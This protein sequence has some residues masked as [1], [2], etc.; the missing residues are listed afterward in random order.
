MSLVCDEKNV[1]VRR[2]LTNQGG[3]YDILKNGESADIYQTKDSILRNMN[4]PIYNDINDQ[5]KYGKFI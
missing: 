3:F 4:D 1:I 2:S 5:K